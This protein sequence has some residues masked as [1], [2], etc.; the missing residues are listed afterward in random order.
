MPSLLKI[1]SNK[2]DIFSKISNP[3]SRY[4][5]N[6][7]YCFIFGNENNEIECSES[8]IFPNET[9]Y[10]LSLA[11]TF[12]QS[13]ENLRFIIKDISWHRINLHKYPDWQNFYNEHLDIIIGNAKFK[14]TE[15][16]GLSEKIDLNSLEFTV[17]NN[18]AYN[19]WDVTFNIFLYSGN[20]IVG[21]N[22]YILQEFMSKEKRNIQISWS[23]RFSRVSDIEIIPEI[24]VMDEDVYIKYKG[25]VGEEK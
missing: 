2:Y 9:K 19:Y 6:I 8:F 20:R 25:G 23:G 22:K 17:Y 13:P 1:E 3:N 16:S 14:P 7:K 21:V 5:C 15:L 12:E 4:L 10:L 18:T 11:K 24:N